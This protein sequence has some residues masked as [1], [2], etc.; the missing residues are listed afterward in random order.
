MRDLWQEPHSSADAKGEG[1][2]EALAESRAESHA[3]G[4]TESGSQDTNDDPNE[5]A[6]HR[7]RLGTRPRGS[8]PWRLRAWLCSVEAPVESNWAQLESRTKARRCVSYSKSLMTCI[9]SRSQ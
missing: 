7:A 9:E 6:M 4:F 1:D 5:R 8:V 3:E 2:A